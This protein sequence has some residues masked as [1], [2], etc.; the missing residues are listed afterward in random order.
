[1]ARA[2]AEPV[3]KER[4]ALLRK[5][6]EVYAEQMKNAEMAFV[7]AARALRELPDDEA[8][9]ELCLR[10]VEPAEAAE[11]LAS[12]LTEIATKAAD[13]GARAC[14]YRALARLQLRHRVLAAEVEGWTK[15]LELVPSGADAL[16][17][18]SRLYSVLRPTR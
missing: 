17:G 8:S 7:A 3:L 11:D 6:A 16:Y 9:L 10:L 15:L 12:L 4:V 5:V 14:L 2:S 18:V 1:E 13:D